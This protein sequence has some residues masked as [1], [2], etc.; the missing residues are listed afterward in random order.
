ML[1]LLY[2]QNF[3][4]KIQ[5]LKTQSAHSESF[6][7]F[8]GSNCHVTN[9]KGNKS[10]RATGEKKNYVDSYYQMAPLTTT[11]LLIMSLTSQ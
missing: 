6:S 3:V 4:W 7:L 2:L 9:L 5:S 11:Q 1:E 8:P 10:G